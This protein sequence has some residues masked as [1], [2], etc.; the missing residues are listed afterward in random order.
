MAIMKVNFGGLQIL[1]PGYYGCPWWDHV[2]RDL[3]R[4][5]GFSEKKINAFLLMTDTLI[6]LDLHDEGL[7]R[8]RSVK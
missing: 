5:R 6:R 3:K 1:K 7:W 8:Q 2:W 4:K